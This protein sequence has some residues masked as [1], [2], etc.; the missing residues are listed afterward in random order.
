M[1]A[2]RADVEYCSRLQSVKWGM[3]MA[4]F[5]AWLPILLDELEAALACSLLVGGL[6]E[7][8]ALDQAREFCLDLWPF[9]K[10]L[11]ENIASVKESLPTSMQSAQ[12]LLGE[13]ADDE[14]VY[15]SLFVKQCLLS[16]LTEQDLRKPPVSSAADRLRNL[17][18]Q[19][20]Q[21]K[22]YA[23]GMFAI[24]TAELAA[25]A[26]ARAVSPF[27]EQYFQKHAASVPKE[28]VEV[29]M[30]WLRL[31]AKPQTRN[32]LLLTRAVAALD[33]GHSTKLPET[34][35]VVLQSIFELWRCPPCHA[36][37][38]GNG[39]RLESSLARA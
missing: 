31:D 8:R 2:E 18:G 28:E 5:A 34:V 37:D 6:D 21:S 1:L 16:G 38:T 11:P 30:E 4:R 33:Q 15:R 29:G 17:M 13:L 10:E 22:D 12:R 20:C 32:A 27:Y 25:A 7:A 26:F 36:L 23:Q 24:V 3:S 14:H 9:I 35:Q 39:A 19:F